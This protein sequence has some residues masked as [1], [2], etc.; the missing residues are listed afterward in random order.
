MDPLPG[1]VFLPMDFLDPAA[2]EK[3]RRALGGEKA[4]LVLSDMAPPTT[5]HRATDHLRIMALCEAAAD[6]SREIL[7]PGGAFLAKVFRGGTEHGLLARLKRDFSKVQHVKPP[8]SRAE[9]PELYLLATGFRPA[10]KE[11]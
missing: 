11:A 1:V 2:P 10:V 8:A 9:S 7:V 3:I 6:F 5:G 4:D